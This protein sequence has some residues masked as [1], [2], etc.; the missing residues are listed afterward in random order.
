M[1]RYRS[2]VRD[3]S[4]RNT[5]VSLALE[6][7]FNAFLPVYDG[8]VDFVL[9]REGDS[10][11][12]KV[13]LKS[14]WTTEPELGRRRYRGPHGGGIAFS[15]G[16]L[17][18]VMPITRGKRYTFLPFLYA[19]MTHALVKPTMRFCKRKRR[20]ISKSATGYFRRRLLNVATLCSSCRD[21]DASSHHAV[22]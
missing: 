14:C 17:H 9:Y 18:E 4:N 7:S 3:V 6:Q 12:R 2:Q 13:Q 16:G 15:T 19:R 21:S 8:G 20:L 5:V 1:S 22:T 11:V 10:L